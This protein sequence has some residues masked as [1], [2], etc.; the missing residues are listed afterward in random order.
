[1]V[2]LFVAGGCAAAPSSNAGEPA[3]AVG[4]GEAAG[5]AAAFERGRW[6]TYHSKRL[7]LS[8]AL[9]D[10]RAWRI[11]D[12][13]TLWLRATHAA[14]SSALLA[15][16]WFEPSPVNDERCYARAREWEPRLPDLAAARIVDDTVVRLPY[17]GLRGTEAG[18]RGMEARGAA[19]PAATI[20]SGA[21]EH[22]DSMAAHVIAG[23]EPSPAGE[24]GG[25]ASSLR[26]AGVG[27]LAAGF[28]VVRGAAVRKCVLV[29]FR[30]ASKDM[31]ELAGRLATVSSQWA[32]SIRVGSALE[33]SLPFAT[34]STKPAGA[35]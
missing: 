30:T 7:E 8:L 21:G 25:T 17:G 31:P 5:E 24:V 20:A 2:S 3:A 15:R 26:D 4:Q 22:G 29:V 13:S 12:H 10:G 23:V 9:P 35:R 19:E 16:V 27:A 14:S 11:D 28:V 6:G 33:P 34:P 1:M 32:S 18:P